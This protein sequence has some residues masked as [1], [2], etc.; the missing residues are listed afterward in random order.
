L[1]SGSVQ[2]Q[3]SRVVVVADGVPPLQVTD[4]STRCCRGGT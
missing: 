3:R 2:V 4:I 1:D